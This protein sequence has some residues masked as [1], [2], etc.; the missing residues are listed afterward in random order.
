MI[1]TKGGSK[2]KSNYLQTTSAKQIQR[3]TDQVRQ[4]VDPCCL[5]PCPHC[6]VTP[7]FFKRHENRSR[8]FYIIVDMVVTAL[9]G[10][11]SR[12]KCPGCNKTATS[13]PGFVIPYKRYTL[14]TIQSFSLFYV[15][16]PAASYRELVAAW[17]LVYEMSPESDSNREPTMEHST[18]H[19]WISTMGS[20][21]RLLQSATDLIIQAD[22]TTRLHRDLAGLNI[23]PGKYKSTSRKRILLTCF[24]LV[25]L[26][27][28]YRA[29]FQTGIFPKLATLSGYT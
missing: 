7:D 18:I 1:Y 25:F 4:G 26:M 10:L 23:S 2:D 8:I 13:Y 29:V 5:P 16:N 27:P 24:Q 3:H 6:G 12:W 21:S 15:Q 28:I 9:Q 11:L 14:P 17:P 20:Y 19:R 22:P